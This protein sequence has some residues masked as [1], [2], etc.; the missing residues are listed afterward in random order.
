MIGAPGHVL[1]VEDNRLVAAVFKAM[2]RDLGFFVS[3]RSGLHDGL[4]SLHRHTY[5]VVAADLA[6]REGGEAGLA[7]A[8][9]AR[10]MRSDTRIIL[11]SGHPMPDGLH[12]R[13]AFLAKPFTTG[14]VLGAIGHRPTP[15]PLRRPGWSERI[16]ADMISPQIQA[17]PPPAART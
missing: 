11:M 15:G 7:L 12:P 14:D 3:V 16:Y 5:D 6:L 1:I 2:L 10:A 17:M 8:L 4:I 9:E 13:I